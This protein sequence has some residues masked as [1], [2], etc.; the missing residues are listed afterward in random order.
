MNFILRDDFSQYFLDLIN[1][2]SEGLGN[3]RLKFQI[4]IVAVI[5][6]GLL[7]IL[8]YRLWKKEVNYKHY[9]PEEYPAKLRK[10]NG[11]LLV[12][13]PIIV[14]D[15]AKNIYQ[16]YSYGFLFYEKTYLFLT[17]IKVSFLRN[18]WSVLIYFVILSSIYK[19]M[20]GLFNLL[21]LFYRK[22]LFKFL[23]LVY[24]PVCVLI[25]GLKYFLVTQVVEPNHN[26]IYSV[27]NQWSESLYLSIGLFL[28]ILFSKRINAAF[29]K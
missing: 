25:D 11:L 3:D 16:F 7:V 4:T 20:F 18:W 29:F 19:I 28:Y 27:F 12:L 1:K 9:Y 10:L 6:A 26:I 23:M 22:R 8:F 5:L 24:I 2:Y 17:E 21:M 14:F 13:I 15:F